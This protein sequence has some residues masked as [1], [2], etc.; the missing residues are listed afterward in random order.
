[1]LKRG[2]AILFDESGNVVRS[3]RGI[4]PGTRLHG[5]LADGDLPLKVDRAGGE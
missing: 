2:Y 4:G 1:V 5:R 3:V